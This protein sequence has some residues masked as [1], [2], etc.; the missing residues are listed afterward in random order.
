MHCIGSVPFDRNDSSIFY[1]LHNSNMCVLTKYNEIS[2]LWR[3]A[4][5]CIMKFP[6][7]CIEPWYGV[8]DSYEKTTDFSKKRGIQKLSSDEKFEFSWS[9]EFKED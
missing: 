4:F 2:G 1:I 3:I 6:F 5:G 8:N 9:A 7:V